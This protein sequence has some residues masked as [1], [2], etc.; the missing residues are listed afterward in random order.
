[1]ARKDDDFSARRGKTAPGTRLR[2]CSRYFLD[3]NRTGHLPHAGARTWLVFSEVPRLAGGHSRTISAHS[4]R[5][6]QKGNSLIVIHLAGVIDMWSW[7]VQRSLRQ[8]GV[9]WTIL[10]ADDNGALQDL[11]KEVL[12]FAAT[13]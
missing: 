2:D 3:V 13:N 11:A 9:V 6:N 5:N 4:G 10:V 7:E 12:S 8:R 1:K